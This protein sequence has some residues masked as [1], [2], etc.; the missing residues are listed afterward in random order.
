MANWP[1]EAPRI[2]RL[3]SSQPTS[4][5][6]KGVRPGAARPPP[7]VMWSSSAWLARRL[8]SARWSEIAD[9]ASE[10]VPASGAAQYLHEVGRP[11]RGGTASP[12]GA[13][14]A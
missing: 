12:A 13:V 10:Q 2:W 7:L 5:H 3:L 6:E 4:F 8:W 1:I 14:A 11:D 9:R